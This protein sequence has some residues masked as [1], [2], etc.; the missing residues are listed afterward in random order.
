[1]I[2][3]N[4]FGII[5][6]T[7]ISKKLGVGLSN[8]SNDWIDG[9]QDDM[10]EEMLIRDH[11]NKVW[12]KMGIADIKLDNY[13]P[14]DLIKKARWDISS[15]EHNSHL[16]IIAKNLIG[17]DVMDFENSYL[18]LKNDTMD[19]PSCETPFPQKFIHFCNT[20]QEASSPKNQLNYRIPFPI[21]SSDELD[22]KPKILN[23]LRAMMDYD[24]DLENYKMECTSSLVSIGS[25][26]DNFLQ[27]EEDFWM[28]DYIINS[29]YCDREYN[30]YHIFKVM[31]LIEMLIINPS[32]NGR[33]VGELERKLPQFLKEDRI[34]NSK[35]FSFAEIMRKLRNKIAHGDYRGIK[36]LLEQYRN[37]FMCNYQYDEFEYSIENWTYLNICCRLD[38]ILNEIVW[39]LVTNKDQLKTI[40]YS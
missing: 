14:S 16:K 23:Y 20:I 38:E 1:M 35:K 33:T 19:S 36:Q 26:I 11:N 28:L 37:E 5:E 40:Q 3:L 6:P 39:E 18:Q 12:D 21:Y 10:L 22:A 24:F 31:S 7:I 30:S 27:G 4:S 17:I 9:L 15:E 32:H 34:E 25:L 8:P 13:H 29:M 2:I